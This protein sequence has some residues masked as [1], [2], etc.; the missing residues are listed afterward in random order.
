VLELIT[1]RHDFHVEQAPL[2]AIA[3]GQKGDWDNY[4]QSFK[5]ITGPH[6]IQFPFTFG[7]PGCP[8]CVHIHWRWG[9]V[10]PE[11]FDDRHDGT[12]IIPAGSTQ[13]VEFTVVAHRDGEEHP[14][15]FHDLINGEGL[16]QQDLVL[17]YSAKGNQA[18]DTF[19]FHGGFFQPVDEADLGVTMTGPPIVHQNETVTYEIEV[20]N[21]GPSFATDVV[22]RDF[23]GLSETQFVAADGAQCSQETPR[24]TLRR[25]VCNLFDIRPGTTVPLKLTFKAASRGGEPLVNHAILDQ[26]RRDPNARNDRA[27]VKT[28]FVP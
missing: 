27:K 11:G 21:N 18:S 4:H 7:A 3:G 19:F 1:K 8:E 10:V 28:E 25:L 22:L 9:L 17:W 15:D 16:R 5:T 20:T 26:R 14:N 13:D 12:P 2:T 6:S 23:W 24:A